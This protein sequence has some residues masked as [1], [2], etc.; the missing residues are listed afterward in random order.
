M[1]TI[2]LFII[3]L[4]LSIIAYTQNGLGTV[5]YSILEPSQFRAING[6]GWVLMDGGLDL[7]NTYAKQWGDTKLAAIS[8]LQKLPDARGVFLRGMNVGQDSTIGDTQKNRKI[9]SY[10]SD[11]F[12]T[13]NH[14]YINYYKY[15]DFTAESFSHEAV[16][17]HGSVSRETAS[18]G[19][20]ETRPRNITLFIYIKVDD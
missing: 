6:H 15:N 10:Q 11:Q 19:G 20:L 2:G 13:H 7:Y 14:K 16:I 1:K 8:G 9:G 5:V 4:F 3:S 12:K 18:S 17:K